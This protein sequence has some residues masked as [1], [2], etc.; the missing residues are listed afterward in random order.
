MKVSATPLVGALELQ[1]E[2]FA[3]DRGFFMEAW[4]HKRYSQAGIPQPFKQANFSESARGVLRGL[5]YHRHQADI[6]VVA[7]GQPFIALVDV[8]PAVS[9]TG[10]PVVETIDAVPGDAFYL[11]AGVAHGFYAREPITLVY[12]VTNEYDG[13][14]ELGFAWDD[15]DAAVAWP[16]PEPIISPRDADAP[17]LAQLIAELRTD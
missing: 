2:F 3:D 14:D 7:A 13:N 4:N 12:L 15:P 16:D 8:R 10:A 5:H 6:W 9:G 11:P 17:S 1:P